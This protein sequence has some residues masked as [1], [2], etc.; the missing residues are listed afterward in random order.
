MHDQSEYLVM[1]G[2]QIVTRHESLV[3]ITAAYIGL[4][5]VLDVD[6]EECSECA[7]TILQYIFFKEE[8]APARSIKQIDRLWQEYCA[9]KKR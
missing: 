9:F 3:V 8:K 5:Y 4:F 6:Y 2:D 7:V 1:V